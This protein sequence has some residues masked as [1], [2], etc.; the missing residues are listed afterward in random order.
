MVLPSEGPVNHTVT[1][2]R[3]ALIDNKGWRRGA[4]VLTKN[5]ILEPDINALQGRRSPLSECPLSDVID[6]SNANYYI[7]VRRVV[8][9]PSVSVNGWVP[10]SFFVPREGSKDNKTVFD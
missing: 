1:H 2:V 3:Y 6:N 10:G 8:S 9:I 7:G 4:A 5:G